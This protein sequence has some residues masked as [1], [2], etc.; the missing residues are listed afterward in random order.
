[1]VVGG[2]TY[3]SAALNHVIALDA[4]TGAVRWR[5]PAS[6]AVRPW[7]QARTFPPPTTREEYEGWQP[8][9]GRSRRTRS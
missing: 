3:L 9:S 6:A 2:T 4:R 1:M 8:D 5:G 7:D